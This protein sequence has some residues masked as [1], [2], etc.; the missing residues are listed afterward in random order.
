MKD[1]IRQTRLRGC[2]LAGL[3]MSLLPSAR[4]PAADYAFLVGV[5]DYDVKQLRKL[6][7][8]RNDILTFRT[9]L[10]ESGFPEK[11]VKILHDDLRT[12]GERRYLA[13]SDRIRAELKLLIDRVTESD[14]I[15]IAFAGHGVQFKDDET[16]Y[17][18]PLD[19]DLKDRKTLI[20]LDEVYDS[21]EACKARRKLLL[22]DACRN[23]PIASI[24]RSAGARTESVTKPQLVKPPSGVVALFS[25]AAGQQSFEWPALKHGLFFNFVIEGWKGAADSGDGELHLEELIH[26]V[27]TK[28]ASFAD[29]KLNASQTPRQRGYFSGRWV[30]RDL[31][32]DALAESGYPVVVGIHEKFFVTL[33]SKNFGED[34]SDVVEGSTYLALI[35]DGVFEKFAEDPDVNGDALMSKMGLV[36]RRKKSATLS[37]ILKFQEELKE[38]SQKHH[39]EIIGDLIVMAKPEFLGNALKQPKLADQCEKVLRDFE[40]STQLFLSI[41]DSLIQTAIDKTL[42]NDSLDDSMRIMLSTFLAP[43]SKTS[44][45]RLTINVTDRVCEFSASPRKDVPLDQLRGSFNILLGPLKLMAASQQNIDPRLLR[46]LS[47]VIE[48]G[49]VKLRSEYLYSLFAENFLS[50]SKK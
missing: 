1:Q 47:F 42:K 35:E 30:L 49:T 28:T 41:D 44:R 10:T 11:N 27:K 18:C 39:C 2:L 45:V 37:Q 46:E 25:C 4:T 16:S 15:I 31:G 26:F 9:V 48:G 17:Y 8:S 34:F 23:D 40:D 13:E 36:A 32:F 24:A 12:V 21:L 33:G 19:A 38:G 20:S 50:N 29:G 22:V 3:V 14:R 5:Q 43:L 7:Y 6:K